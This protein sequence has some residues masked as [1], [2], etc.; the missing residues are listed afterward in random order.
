MDTDALLHELAH[1]DGLPKKALKEA[2]AHRDVL[3]PV[4]LGTIQSYLDTPSEKR[5]GKTPLFFI[6]HLLGEWREKSAYGLLARLLRCPPEDVDDLFGDGITTTTHRVMAAVFD[7]DPQPLFDIILDRNADEYV[8]SRM[9]ETLAMVVARGALDR[10]IAARFLTNAFMNLE[11][12]SECFVWHGWQEAIA[13][14]GLDDL[15]SLVKKAFDRRFID[16]QW[17]GYQSFER[18]LEQGRGQSGLLHTSDDYTL[19]GD[20][21]EELSSWYCFSDQ[22]KK[23]QEKRRR[24]PK[25]EE[26]ES[27]EHPH[28][29]PLRG[30]GRNDPCPC[31]SGKKFKKCCMP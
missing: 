14:L 8:R 28:T 15:R 5:G 6:F 26:W 24:Q 23:D 17:I 13:L 20:T 9:C 22:Y 2:S 11:P 19:F 1:A 29:N 30:V 4:F 3:V 16:P 7:G 25:G 31:G 21:I 27:R 18:H 12:Q 10:K